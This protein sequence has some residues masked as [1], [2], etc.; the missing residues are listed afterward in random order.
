MTMP[1]KEGRYTLFHGNC[2]I[3]SHYC[4][5]LKKNFFWNLLLKKQYATADMKWIRISSVLTL[6]H[7]SHVVPNLL[8]YKIGIIAPVQ[9]SS[10]K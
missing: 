9:A 2:L 10:V 1:T 3:F 5:F 7:S 8:I 6:P 4:G